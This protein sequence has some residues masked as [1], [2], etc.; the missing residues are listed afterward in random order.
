MNE[1]KKSPN[2][3]NAYYN[4]ISKVYFSGSQRICGLSSA[5]YCLTPAALSLGSLCLHSTLIDGVGG[6][7]GD[8]HLGE[9]SLPKII[10]FI[11]SPFP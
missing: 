4:R 11:F 5:T 3:K 2:K 1:F 9:T 8:R 7:Q 10:M 6:I